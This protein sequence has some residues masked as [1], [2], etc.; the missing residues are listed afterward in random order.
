MSVAEIGVLDGCFEGEGLGSGERLLA[1]RIEAAGVFS[2]RAQR[3]REEA[4]GHFIVLPIGGRDMLGDGK[5]IHVAGELDFACSRWCGKGAAS[6]I[7]KRRHSEF[8]KGIGKRRALRESR[9]RSDKAYKVAPAR[10]VVTLDFGGPG[11]NAW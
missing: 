6:P 4:R 10:R 2:L 7:D 9:R 5:E 3:E 11:Q 1:G 8:G